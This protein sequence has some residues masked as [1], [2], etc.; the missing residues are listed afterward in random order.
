MINSHLAYSP[1]KDFITESRYS[2]DYIEALGMERVQE[3]YADQKRDFAEAVV[4]RNVFTDNEG[5]SY[6]RIVWAD[7]FQIPST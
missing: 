3:L 7:E 1:E 5:L 6:N 2:K 4:L